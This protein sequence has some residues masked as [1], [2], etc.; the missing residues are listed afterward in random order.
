MARRHQPCR[1]C[2]NHRY[3]RSRG[4]CHRCWFND[5]IRTRYPARPNNGNVDSDG[6]FCGGYA[7]PE[8]TA[9]LPATPGKL[10]DLAARVE[11]KVALFHPYDARYTLE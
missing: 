5:A 1:H 11:A 7:L 4:L 6:D 2:G 10:D 8:P 9:N 3:L